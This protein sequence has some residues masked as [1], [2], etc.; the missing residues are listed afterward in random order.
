MSWI[1]WKREIKFENG[2]G[3][4]DHR[5]NEASADPGACCKASLAIGTPLSQSPHGLHGYAGDYDWDYTSLGEAGKLGVGT[6]KQLDFKVRFN[7]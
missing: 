3:D 7:G 2:C 5:P 4:K 1:S 6:F